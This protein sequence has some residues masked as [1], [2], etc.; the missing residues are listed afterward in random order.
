M[1]PVVAVSRGDHEDMLLC[2]YTVPLGDNELPFN[3]F[4]LLNAVAPDK[5]FALLELIVVGALGSLVNALTRDDSAPQ[6]SFCVFFAL[7]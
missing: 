7:T 5:L 2:L 4:A 3:C 6:S 1:L